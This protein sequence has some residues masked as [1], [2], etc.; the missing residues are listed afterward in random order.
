MGFNKEI[1]RIKELAKRDIESIRR[2]N[3][4]VWIKKENKNEAILNNTI[5]DLLTWEL[6]FRGT[7]EECENY[8][9]N[10]NLDV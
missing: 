1:E 10:N 8:C 2:N 3:Y 5:L 7:K 6:V 4:Y 9:I